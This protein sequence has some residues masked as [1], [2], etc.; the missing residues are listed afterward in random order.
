VTID[1]ELRTKQTP[2]P[3]VPSWLVVAC[4]VPGVAFHVDEV[5]RGE[6][7]ALAPLSVA[8]GR[9]TVRFARPGYTSTIRVVTLTRGDG[10]HV[11]CDIKPSDQLP[12]LESGVLEVSSNEV[13][14]SVWVDGVQ[15]DG[16]RLPIGPHRIEVRRWGFLPWTKDVT[17]SHQRPTQLHA[18]LIPTLEFRQQY[19]SSANRE[20]TLAYVTGA[21]GLAAAASAVVLFVYGSQRFDVWQAQRDQLLADIETGT[22]Q[23]GSRSRMLQLADD[24]AKIQR[25][26]AAAFALALLGGAMLATATSLFIWGKSPD[27]FTPGPRNVAKNG[28]T[29]NL[30]IAW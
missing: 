2:A 19:T 22:D 7:P 16:Q 25:T 26:D 23:E 5:S 29:H 20:R 21:T 3:F 8:P 15:F 18:V 28:L 9:R 6:T 13:H 14:A 24:E 11:S 12:N 1:I 27:R 4:D 10:S 30:S 17:I